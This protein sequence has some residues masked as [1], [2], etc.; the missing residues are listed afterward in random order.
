MRRTSFLI[1]LCLIAAPVTAQNINVPADITD[2]AAWPRVMPRFAKA[3]IGFQQAAEPAELASLFRAQ[4]V[5]GLYGDALA[6]LERLR[7][8]L[9]DDPSPRVRARYLDY[10]LYARSRLT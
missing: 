4:L 1:Y 2:E 8:P 9:K 7:S 10:V 6:S 3:V 5:A